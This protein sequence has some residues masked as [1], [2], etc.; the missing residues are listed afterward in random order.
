M[1]NKEN[2]DPLNQNK[3]KMSYIKIG[4]NKVIYPAT[5]T[6]RIFARLIDFLLAWIVPFILLSIYYAKFSNNNFVD[7]YDTQIMIGLSVSF[8]SF[9]LFFI[10]IPLLNFKNIGQSLG[11]KFLKIT[12]LYFREKNNILSFLI[13]ESFLGILLVI[14]TIFF[15]IVGFNP[16]VSESLYFSLWNDHKVFTDVANQIPGKDPSGQIDFIINVWG[17]GFYISGIDG[18]E[19]IIEGWQMGLAITGMV[20][21]WLFFISVIIVWITAGTNT[22]KR[23]LHDDLAKTAVV[24]LKTIISEEQAQDRYQKLLNIYKVNSEEEEK[25]NINKKEDSNDSL[26]PFNSSKKE[27]DK[28]IEKDNE[29]KNSENKKEE[30]P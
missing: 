9:F 19:Y 29:K 3:V 18:K 1:N 21:G 30:K 6:K 5:I 20:I 14:P 13:R 17:E 16:V 2:I 4:D 23:G 22:Q 25:I 15:L 12:P 28:K 27:K 11:K 7:P 24:D 26:S 8:A 10:L